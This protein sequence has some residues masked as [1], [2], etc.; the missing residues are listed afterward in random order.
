MKRIDGT[1]FLANGN[2][3]GKNAFQDYNATTGAQGTVPNASTFNSWQEELCTYVETWL[4]ALNASDNTQIFQAIS[5]HIAS[6]M[7]GMF[8]AEPTVPASMVVNLVAGFI[9]SAASV[10]QVA[11]QSTPAF[12]APAANPRIDRIVISRTTGV[13]SVIAGAPAASPVPP[14]IPAA[15]VPIA[16]VALTTTTTAITAAMITDERDLP[17]LGL[18]SGAY[19]AAS[20]TNAGGSVS[21]VYP[22][23][24]N[25]NSHVAG[26]AA[27]AGTSAGDVVWDTV[28]YQYWTCT[29]TG[30][31]ATAVWQVLGGMAPVSLASA[32]TTDLGTAPSTTVTITGTTTITSLGTSASPGVIYTVYFAASLTLTYNAA[33][34]QLPGKANITTQPGDTAQFIQFSSG[35][36]VC[37]DYQTA[38]GQSVVGATAVVGSVR[39]LKAGLTAAA[40]SVTFTWDEAVVATALGGVTYKVTN[41]AGLT[42]TMT[43]TGAGG[44]D[45]GSVAASTWYSI[46]AAYNPANGAKCLFACLASTSNGS[47]YSGA[48]APSGYTAT[49]LVSSWSTTSSSQLSI[50]VQNDR[51][52]AIAQIVALSTP[53]IVSWSPLSISSS[54]P[55]N[56]KSVNGTLSVNVT[57]SV[58]GA[59]LM[60]ASNPSGTINAV[61]CYA[62]EQGGSQSITTSCP[63]KCDIITP[64]TIYWGS[65]N[66]N[67]TVTFSVGIGGFDI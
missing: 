44:L 56:A 1:N 27:V 55:P 26:V 14:A 51:H 64:Q 62:E 33:S 25:P 60:I 53:N 31:A 59:Y 67:S 42:L 15:A 3:V 54:V 18:G 24:G 47:V 9:P 63:F 6:Q 52:A 32:A 40:S 30:T 34:L 49:A 39:N 45:T 11:G 43:G 7:R 16:Q 17:P 2:G 50:G 41:A 35:A 8:A 65:A 38:S 29:T 22:Y 10:V 58:G 19:L 28:H 4:G 21:T 37:I 61:V 5:A 46:Y 57:G 20:S 13:L 12:V 36:W 48:N 66:S 23:A